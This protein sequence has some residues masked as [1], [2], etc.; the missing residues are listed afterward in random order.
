MLLLFSIYF[1][2][3]KNKGYRQCNYIYI[4]NSE[5]IISITYLDCVCVFTS[6]TD[7]LSLSL[8][9]DVF[10]CMEYDLFICLYLFYVYN[11]IYLLNLLV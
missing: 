6:Y 3:H 5:Y 2:L 7:I 8:F 1:L 11:S 9:I 4:I 10:V